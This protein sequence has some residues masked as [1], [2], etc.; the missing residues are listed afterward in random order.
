[1]IRVCVLPEEKAAIEEQARKAGMSVSAYLRNVGLNYEPTSVVDYDAVL[2][3]I[4]INADL[5]RVGGLLKMWLTNDERINIL[6]G[7]RKRAIINSALQRIETRAEE[8]A[9]LISAIMKEKRK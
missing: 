9:P 2:D 6:N 7:A 5:G 4:K 8:M 3:L 1:M